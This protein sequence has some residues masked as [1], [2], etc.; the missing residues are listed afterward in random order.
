MCVLGD[1]PH[2]EPAPEWV[3]HR[4]RGGQMRSWMDGGGGS[5]EGTSRRPSSMVGLSERARC[6]C[7]TWKT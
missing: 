3:L 1:V 6:M 7:S 2:V 4:S 5:Q